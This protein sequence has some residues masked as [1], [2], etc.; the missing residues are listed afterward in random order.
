MIIEPTNPDDVRNMLIGIRIYL[1][2]VKASTKDIYD[3]EKVSRRVKQITDSGLY[4]II[5][6][7][8]VIDQLEIKHKN[9]GFRKNSYLSN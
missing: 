5:Q 8:D 1:E 7:N 9:H 4:H 3:N 6:I 2:T